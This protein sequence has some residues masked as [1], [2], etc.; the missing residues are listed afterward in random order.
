MSAISNP[1]AAADQ[2]RAAY[3]DMT[4]QLG[5]LGL[6]TAIPEGVRALAEKTVAHTRETCDRSMEAFDASVAAFERSFEA[7]GK[8]AATFNR[9]IIDI[10]RRNVNSNFDLATSLAGA[11]DL[12]DIVKL[13]AAHWRKQVDALTAQAEEVRVLSLKV[14]ADPAERIESQM[15]RGAD[16]RVH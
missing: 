4:A 12:Y 10:A 3:R 2:A 15:A 13:Q 8:G 7:A 11:K 6:D 14:T 16:G 1:Q 5:R 9:K